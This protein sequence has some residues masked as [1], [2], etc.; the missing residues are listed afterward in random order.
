LTKN[1]C[2][3]CK[4]Q[5]IHEEFII[6][7]GI[8]FTFYKIQRKEQRGDKNFPRGTTNGTL[9]AAN[10]NPSTFSHCILSDK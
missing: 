2:S 9:A 4:N 3:D 1:R 6:R 5:K 8:I 10:L 7:E